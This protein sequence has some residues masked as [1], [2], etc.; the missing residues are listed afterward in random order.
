M[1]KKNSFFQLTIRKKKSS[2]SFSGNDQ[3]DDSGDAG[4][5]RISRKQFIAHY[6]EK[7]RQ[8][9][10]IK[11]DKYVA[12]M[13]EFL[14]NA[15]KSGDGALPPQSLGTG[16]KGK[17][18]GKR[19]NLKE[20]AA[21]YMAEQEELEKGGG[22]ATINRDSLKRA[23]K[24]TD[25]ELFEILYSLIMPS[26]KDKVL[27]EDVLVMTY[28]FMRNNASSEDFAFQIFDTQPQLQRGEIYKREFA[29]MIVVM[30]ENNLKRLFTIFKG[31][32][33]FFQ[34]L[35]NEHSEELFLF[36]EQMQPI[37]K[38]RTIVV[39]KAR[40]LFDNYLEVD[41]RHQVNISHPL[42][43][44]I[45]QLIDLAETNA[46]KKSKA[47]MSSAVFQGAV[48]E[49]HEMLHGGFQ[50]FKKKIVKD[51]TLF[52]DFTWSSLSINKDAEGMPKEVFITW[53]GKNPGVFGCLDKIQK[54]LLSVYSKNIGNV[55]E[56]VTP[57]GV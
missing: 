16:R 53:A 54:G 44:S 28:L 20:A 41:A 26:G 22:A 48:D 55:I 34:H 2:A 4:E 40:K 42:R 9:D 56:L 33:A 5:D 23:L 29:E 31:K 24:F 14:K 51:P 50:R 13:T 36:Y 10:H 30:L 52:V 32:E 45:R 15:Q 18:K 11:F 38:E 27:V 25:S 12:D 3:F 39:K 49:V 17:G 47:T 1:K 57:S 43:E 35:T 8:E 19:K 37:L 21:E 7:I 46:G 6:K